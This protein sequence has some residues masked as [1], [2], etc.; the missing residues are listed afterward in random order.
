MA[1]L[2]LN[3]PR[4][5]STT[6]KID[7]RQQQ[8][9]EDSDDVIYTN[10]FPCSF[11]NDLTFY[12]YDVSVEEYHEL[13]HEYI[14]VSNR[15]KRRQFV[16]D[17]LFTK[18]IHPTAICWYDEGS[19][20]YST[21]N[22]QDKLPIVYEDEEQ[23]RRHRLTVNSLSATSGTHDLDQSS[24]RIIETLIKQALKEQFKAIGSV[25]YRWDEEPRQD[26][27]YD[28]LTGFKQAL[29][30]TESGPTLNL[31]ITVTRFYPH[32]DL[33]PFIWERILRQR[34]SDFRGVLSDQQY[35]EIGNH[36]KDIEVTT[37]QSEYRSKY[38]LTG[39]FS[40]K[41]P[42]QIVIKE[43]GNLLDYYKGLDC[44]LKYPRLYCFKAYPLGKPQFVVDLPIELC[45]LREWQEVKPDES[46][47]PVPAPPVN[48]RYNAIMAAIRNCNFVDNSL[49]KEIQLKVDCNDMMAIPYD[50]LHQRQITLSRQGR[51]TQ[52]I[53]IDRMGFIYLADRRQGNARQIQEKL[54]NSF[55][56]VR[57]IFFFR[58][59]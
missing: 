44:E 17:I 46:T 56:E 16:S 20:M 29:C 22:F 35:D 26:G 21:T 53:S 10:H 33:L 39:T 28:L 27:P 4:E 13:K 45:S 42:A 40:E 52:S 3:T 43:K 54:L 5:Q 50:T 38:V 12:Q 59:L 57:I 15:E 30:L 2:A 1:R 36:L 11:A 23:R 37:H 8:Q 55:Y 19:C 32:L 51:Y 9:D 41:L 18:K 47:R 34:K 7:T 31:D 58:F 6:P 48:E 25:F 49:F 24:I 14:N